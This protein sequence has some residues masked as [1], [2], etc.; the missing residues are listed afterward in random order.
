MLRLCPRYSPPVLLTL[1]LVSQILRPPTVREHRAG[2]GVTEAAGDQAE[3]L[4]RVRWSLESLAWPE[5]LLRITF[6]YHDNLYNESLY[7][8]APTPVGGWVDFTIPADQIPCH[9]DF[10]FLMKVPE[11]IQYSP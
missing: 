10:Q 11:N 8:R 3:F 5:C 2:R 7:S 9:Q 4:V 6:D 1:R